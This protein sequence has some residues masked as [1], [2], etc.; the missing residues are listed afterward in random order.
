MFRTSHD[1]R[2]LRHAA[3]EVVVTWSYVFTDIMELGVGEVPLRTIKKK[4]KSFRHLT[5]MTACSGRY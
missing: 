4:H 2:A 5:R 3:Y 1:G